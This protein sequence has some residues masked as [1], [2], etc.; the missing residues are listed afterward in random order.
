MRLVNFFSQDTISR[1]NSSANL[2]S[3]LNKHRGML[4]ER[5]A[6]SSYKPE[7]AGSVPQPR[8]LV[9]PVTLS[10]VGLFFLFFLFSLPVK[11]WETCGASPAGTPG[12]CYFFFF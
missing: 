11:L 9:G 6:R 5:L 8:G 3:L 2:V 4:V 7:A 1:M 12:N 10:Y